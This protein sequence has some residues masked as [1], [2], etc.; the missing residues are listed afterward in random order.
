MIQINIL[1]PNKHM[2][3]LEGKDLKDLDVPEKEENTP[4][5]NF[6]IYCDENPNAL[7]C[8]IYED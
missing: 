8:R 3:E 6:Q 4:K 7:E 2:E 1:Y 5:T